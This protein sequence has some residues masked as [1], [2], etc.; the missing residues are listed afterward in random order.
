MQYDKFQ[1]FEA[2]AR[3]F[4]NRLS[5]DVRYLEVSAKCN[6]RVTEIFRTLL[7]LSGFPRCK[8]GQVIISIAKLPCLCELLF[9]IAFLKRLGRDDEK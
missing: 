6:I 3:A 8:V 2:T 7:E 1:I 4:T 9:M 5:A